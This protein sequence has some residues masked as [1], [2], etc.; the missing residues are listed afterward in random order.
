[1]TK[2]INLFG[3][4][5]CGKSTTAAGLFYKMKMAGYS[6][7]LVTEYPKELVWDGRMEELSCQFKVTGEQMW[8]HQRLCGKTEYVITDSPVLLGLCYDNRLT[9]AQRKGIIDWFTSLDNENF[10]IQ[11]DSFKGYYPHGRIH[12]DKESFALQTKIKDLLSDNKIVYTEYKFDKDLVEN[13][14]DDIEVLNEKVKKE[15]ELQ[16]PTLSY[17]GYGIFS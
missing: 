3:A 11:R 12:N 13:I 8:R 5:C 14:F 10:F 7:E 2:I 15:K 16:N 6:V 9:E 1:M 17:K 4:P